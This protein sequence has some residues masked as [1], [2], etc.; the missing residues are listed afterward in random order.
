MN[1]AALQ[2]EDGTFDGD[3]TTSRV[4]LKGTGCQ[5]KT[6]II[7]FH[8]DGTVSTPDVHT[9]SRVKELQM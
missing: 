7:S 2:V 6:I 5:I 4:A 8:Q 1:H 3:Y 9:I